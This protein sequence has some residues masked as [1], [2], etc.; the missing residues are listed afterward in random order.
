MG[1]AQEVRYLVEGAREGKRD[2]H[3][4]RDDGEHLDTDAP[5]QPRQQLRTLEAVRPDERTHDDHDHADQKQQPLASG[6]PDEQLR[7]GARTVRGQVPV[8]HLPR[9]QRL[10]LVGQQVEGRQ[11]ETRPAAGSGE[12]A[13]EQPGEDQGD[14]WGEQEGVQPHVP[15][16]GRPDQTEQR[17]V[18]LG[19]VREGS[20][21][22]GLECV[23]DPVVLERDRGAR[24][25][26]HRVGRL[27]LRLHQPQDLGGLEHEQAGHEGS[28]EPHGREP[29]DVVALRRR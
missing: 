3:R 9:P 29:T 12:A 22:P 28:Q 21:A 5:E 6:E 8:G 13:P 7:P 27:A 18:D 10:E 14:S 23:D 17:L 19:P 15:T 26:V 11:R 4:Q 16:D 24:Q 2:Q 1:G 25:V 20:G